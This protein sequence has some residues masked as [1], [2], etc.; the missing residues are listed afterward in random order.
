MGLDI[1][2]GSLTRYYTH[3]WETIVQRVGR[4]QGIPVVI[5]RT[6]ESP[7][8]ITDP[9]TIR[10]LILTWRSLMTRT[11]REAGLIDGELGWSEEL[12]TPYF[13]DKP[14]RDCYG[15]VQLL[16]A[17][18]EEGKPL[19]GSAYPAKLRED[20]AK[21]SALNRRLRARTQPRYAHLYACEFWLPHEMKDSFLAPS[22]AGNRARIGSVFGLLRELETLNER[23]FHGST[24]DLKRWRAEMPNGADVAFEPKAKTGLAI[25]LELAAA[26]A[27][28]RLPMVLDF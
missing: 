8:A 20:W 21:D 4:E 28:E 24:D 5:K 3:D 27:R 19:L 16:G 11:L 7:D 22:P 17:H 25:M 10:D 14:G 15:A 1:Y 23:T 12:E 2:V 18:E 13:T 9:A 6:N 26:A